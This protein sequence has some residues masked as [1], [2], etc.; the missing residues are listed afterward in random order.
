MNENLLDICGLNAFF[1]PKQVLSDVAL[2]VRRGEKYALVGESGSGK[3]VLAQAVIRLN[4][5]VRLDGNLQFDGQN[6]LSLSDKALQKIRG[7][8]IGMVFQ[9]PMSALNPVQTVGMQIAEVLTLHLGLRRKEA[10]REAIALLEETG[11]NDAVHKVHAYPFQLSGGQRQRAMIAMAV[12]AK[13]ELLI[14]DEPTTALDVAVQAQILDLLARLQHETGMS[15]LYI[16]HDLRV[17]RRFADTVSVMQTGRVVESN[18]TSQIFQA[19][20]HLY[21]QSL[22]DAVP[23]PLDEL[24]DEAAPILLNARD[25]AVSISRKK[26]WFR[27]VDFPLLHPLSFTLRAGQTLGIVGESGSGKTTLAKALLRLMPFEGSLNI[28]G[29]DWHAL[30][31]KALTRR[32]RDIQIV[33][34][35]PFGALN[36]RMT[37]GEIVGE[38]LTVHEPQLS[39]DER[40]QRVLA[41]LRDVHLDEDISERYPHEFSGGQRQR[42]AIARALIVRPKVL[43]LDEPTSALDVQLQK[44]LLQLLREIQNQYHLSM[45]FISHDL[46]VI[47]ALAH[48][49]LVLQAGHLVEYGTAQEIFN[50]PNNRYTQ[51]LLAAKLT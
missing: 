49:V 37:I 38:A 21:T 41:V 13:P 32:R 14:A 44:K 7:R 45:V 51:K 29:N 6:I 24:P 4:P 50:H 1:G 36:P 22:I 20:Q 8:R 43:I 40:R 46:A 39:A 9:E 2:R 19:P 31:G 28:A 48:H 30:Q 3:T 25:M 33:F 23:P 12:A 35:D 15:V 11:I 10:W 16:S 27:R 18:E 26:G 17:V 42:I 47:R 34:Q 5:D